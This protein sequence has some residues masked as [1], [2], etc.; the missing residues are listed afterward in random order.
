MAPPCRMFWSEL[1]ARVGAPSLARL[2]PERAK[3]AATPSDWRNLFV[4][5]GDLEGWIT[6]HV[7][8]KVSDTASLALASGNRIA[9][10]EF[11]FLM[12]K[13][14]LTDS[15]GGL[16]DLTDISRSD[17]SQATTSPSNSTDVQAVSS[18]VTGTRRAHGRCLSIRTLCGTRRT[19][20]CFRRSV[21]RH[22]HQAVQPEKCRAEPRLRPSL[23]RGTAGRGDASDCGCCPPRQRPD[24]GQD[25]PSRT[26]E[27]AHRRRFPPRAKGAWGRAGIRI[28]R[29][30]GRRVPCDAL[31]PLHQRIYAGALP[32]APGSASAVATT[33]S[34]LGWTATLPT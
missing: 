11:L 19:P 18:R 5:A 17:V 25:D 13:F 20:P 16:Y 22:H 21:G 14:A 33:S 26:G 23:V 24:R 34:T 27:V 12:P 7:P 8:T 2:G 15:R 32:K 30:R 1:Q 6:D 28:P 29:R 31:R 3:P 9:A 4:R 10:H